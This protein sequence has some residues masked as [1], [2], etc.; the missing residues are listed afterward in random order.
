MSGL[1]A[2]C[3]E[4]CLV[5]SAPRVC[6]AGGSRPV[7]PST[8]VPEY[9]VSAGSASASFSAALVSTKTRSSCCW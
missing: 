8:S 2:V 6:A 7:W 5:R 9:A 3:V 1:I 4:E